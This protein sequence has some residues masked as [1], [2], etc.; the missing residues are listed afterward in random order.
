MTTG[1]DKRT[2]AIEVNG[3]NR[4]IVSFD[5]MDT[6]PSLHFPNPNGFIEGARDDVIGLRIEIDAENDV[7]VATEDFD[8]V[9]SV[10]VPDADGTV[11]GSG[12]DV[13]G[14]G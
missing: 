3:S 6:L 1:N 13:V 14:I 11:V 2:I 7:C 12:A 9:T 4:H 10:G 8:T 5:N